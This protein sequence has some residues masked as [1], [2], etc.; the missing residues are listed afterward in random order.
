MGFIG[1]LIARI[2]MSFLCLHKSNP[3]YDRC[4]ANSDEATLPPHFC[5]T[6]EPTIT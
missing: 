2:V 6:L 4:V 3:I 5:I 1:R